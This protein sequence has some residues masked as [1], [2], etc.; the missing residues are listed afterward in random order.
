MIPK[1]AFTSLLTQ[2]LGEI[3]TL[4]AEA[5]EMGRMIAELELRI[6]R[7]LTYAHL[8]HSVLDAAQRDIAPL[9]FGFREPA[10]TLPYLKP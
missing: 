1:N 5:A 7:E 3:A 10:Q 8:K 9:R 4:A 6:A 2:E